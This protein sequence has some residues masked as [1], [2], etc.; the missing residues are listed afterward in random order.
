[1]QSKS[2][3]LFKV[4]LN[5]FHPGLGASFLHNLP[6]EEVKEILKQTVDSD[7]T[8][9]ALTWEHDLITH[10]HYS[11]L[12]PLI[13]NIPKDLQGPTVA[14]LPEPQSSRLKVLLKIK[15]PPSPL[16][17]P[18]KTFLIDR[19]FHQWDPKDAIPRKYLPHSPLAYLLDLS[20]NEL[21]ELI[22]Y[23]ALHD[24][25]DAIRHIV[26]KKTLTKIYQCLTPK[27]QQYT[28]ICLHQ[29]EKVVGPKLNLHKWDGDP[30]KL[31]I[32]LHKHGLFRF[33]KALSGQSHNFMWHLTHTL[34]NGRGTA[35][36]RYYS[37]DPVPNVTPHLIQQLQFVNNFLKQKSAT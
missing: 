37:P 24:L 31:T 2:A 14:A 26:D 25:A 21:V 32:L 30:H 20:K 34:D 33:G 19:L 13:Q 12:A 10:T 7:D 23:L 22:E 16:S 28:R 15:M 3:I 4:L 8:S 6:Q 1:M 27:K 18:V 5:R 17:P 29:K 35:L 36:M 9:A 11:W